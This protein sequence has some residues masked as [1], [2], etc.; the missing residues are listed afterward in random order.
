MDFIF[1]CEN[2]T[3]WYSF[4]RKMMN[5]INI[6]GMNSF[7]FKKDNNPFFAIMKYANSSQINMIPLI[8]QPYALN[9]NTKNNIYENVFIPVNFESEK[10]IDRKNNMIKVETSNFDNYL[11]VVPLYD[12]NEGFIKNTKN[13]I[14]DIKKIAG[15]KPFNFNNFDFRKNTIE[16]NYNKLIEYNF[17]CRARNENFNPE[18]IM[19]KKELENCLYFQRH[20]PEKAYKIWENNF[21]KI[22]NENLDF[23]KLQNTYNTNNNL[24]TFKKI[25]EKYFGRK[26]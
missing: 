25:K 15:I 4:R 26:R 11:K 24:N 9:L 5:D 22:K 14:S 8:G 2:L 13:R 3:H 23:I 1:N 7:I 12:C 21:R 18:N 19:N 10:Y 16:S 17:R 6:Q 20:N